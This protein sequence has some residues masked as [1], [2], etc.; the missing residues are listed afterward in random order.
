MDAARTIVLFVPTLSTEL[1]GSMEFN[2]EKTYHRMVDKG[3]EEEFHRLYDK[4]Y[5]SLLEV[6]GED[7]VVPNLIAGEERYSDSDYLNRS[8]HDTSMVIGKFQRATKEEALEAVETAVSAFDK[9]GSMDY[10]ERV[11]IIENARDLM[12]EK[13]FHLGAVVTLDNGKNRYE[14]MADVDEA[15]DFLSFYCAHMRE[16]EGFC[17]KTSS[18][19]PEEKTESVLRPYGAWAVIC[20][21]NFPAAIT[22]G[23][24]ASALV[25]GNT[26]VL[27]PP[28]PA[29][30][31]V[32]E[33]AHIM[34]EAGVPGGAINYLSGAGSV[35]G[36]VLINSPDISGI[37]FTG[38]KKVG[39]HILDNS[40]KKYPRPVIAEMGG[41]NP[42]IVS[43][44]ADMENAVEGVYKSAFGYG[45]QKCSAC[46]RAYI[47]EP[48]YDEFLKKLV[49]MTRKTRIGDPSVKENYLGPV[50]HEEAYEDYQKYV[51]MA[52]E[53]GIVEVGGAVEEKK[54]TER[55]YYVKP[56]V[57]TGLP[58]DHY[59]IKNELFLPILCVQ[60]F[61]TL[62]N[63]LK[64]ANDVQFGLTAGIFT[65]DDEEIEYFFENIEAGVVYSNRTKGGSTG[66]MVGGQSFGGWKASGSS[67]KGTGGPYYLQQFMREQSRTRVED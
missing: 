23:M 21:F 17:V 28:S 38:S 29:P 54:G 27:K 18:P 47:Q 33:V 43:A 11:S 8:P 10:T 19:F 22:T 51:K 36:D 64:K 55:G 15:I 50:I 60:E 3:K 34:L 49:S 41:K 4:A 44:N 63:A 62:E 42:V 2:N 37:V 25:T 61:S 12:R 52:K 1:S 7:R 46:S 58:E 59:L 67:G 45:G 26:V 48:V 14:A 13:K 30:L 5:K 57:V 32:Y 31:P 16:N 39:Y 6:C 66:A 65:E 40:V 53:D 56:T 24:T 9:W 20:P 35:V